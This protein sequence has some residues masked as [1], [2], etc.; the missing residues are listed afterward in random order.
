M[1]MR[2]VYSFRYITNY[3]QKNEIELDWRQILP[4]PWIILYF[5][6]SFFLTFY[7]TNHRTLHLLVGIILFLISIF[8]MF[9]LFLF[10]KFRF[11]KEKEM[12]QLLKKHFFEKKKD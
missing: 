6:I 8:L 3:F 2:I 4:H 10:L 1:L 11:K 7:G 9:F 5:I 12:I